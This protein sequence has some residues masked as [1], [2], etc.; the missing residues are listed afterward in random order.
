[1]SASTGITC[2]ICFNLLVEPITNQCN[3]TFCLSCVKAQ[4][5]QNSTDYTQSE[6]EEC[7]FCCP[8]CNTGHSINK[9]NLRSI[10]NEPLAAK[11]AA[12]A[13]GVDGVMYCQW[14]E[15][16]PATLHCPD[17]PYVLCN[18]CNVAV[19][20]NSSKRDHVV[21]SVE[22]HRGLMTISKKCPIKHHD[23]YK[24]DFYC[25]RCEELC[26]AFC[27]Q[28]GP[29]H[30]HENVVMS[31]AAYEARQRLSKDLESLTNMKTRVENQALEMNRVCAQYRDTY[32]NVEGLLGDRFAAFH[33]QLASKEIEVRAQ[34]QALRE[35]GDIALAKSRYQ[36]LTKL[37]AINE[38][39]LQY[40]RL[41]HGGADYEI[42]ENRSMVSCQMKGDVPHVSGGVFRINDLGD[43]HLTGLGVGLD[44]STI[45]STHQNPA[46]TGTRGNAIQAN[47]ISTHQKSYSD[48][49]GR[50]TSTIAPAQMARVPSSSRNG[51]RDS[52]C[53]L[54]A[55]TLVRLTFTSDPDVVMHESREGTLLQ[56][57]Q[58][59]TIPQIGVRSN[60]SFDYLH[61]TLGG[62]FLQWRIRLDNVYDSKVGIVEKVSMDDPKGFYWRPM[63]TGQYEG[64]IGV[65][66]PSLRTVPA[67]KRG[68]VL[69]FT[70]D[71]KGATLS[72][73]VNHIDYGP[74]ISDVPLNY[75]PCV[76]LR[77][78]EGLTVVQ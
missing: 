53:S 50:S 40:R 43:L 31:K 15:D 78:G 3:H 2:G 69:T 49:V 7:V 58:G 20:K 25:T 19:H 1:M 44:L 72:I 17:C 35:D 4:L 60:E 48:N 32:D 30:M 57:T 39:V 11:V 18:D 65:L 70:L 66:L 13:K 73:M 22:S 68:D 76:I 67:C 45:M 9:S 5:V 29:H 59:S 28:M 74:I 47:T 34:L 27:L 16:V 33:Q 38:A 36:Y 77:P 10:I 64:D 42:L 37:D 21:V 54:A 46:I 14:C 23:E 63:K 62:D 52:S 26:C 61:Q 12:L 75:C 51:I 56:C 6:A 24:L 8:L 55:N 41:Q 71:V